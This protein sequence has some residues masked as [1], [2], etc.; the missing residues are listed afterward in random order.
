MSK[1]IE[2]GNEVFTYPELTHEQASVIQEAIG[3]LETRMVKGEELTQAQSAKHYCQLQLAG[4]QEEHFGC[5]FLDSKHRLIS[6]ERL[7]RGTLGSTH[8]Y[9]R[10]VLKRVVQTNAAAVIFT[11]NH[12]SGCP[13]PS[14]QDIR[15]T[16]QLIQLLS[17]I[18]VRVLDHIVVGTEGIESFAER[19]II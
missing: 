13:E 12:P 5:L 18:D 6:F 8:V 3:I 2:T 7:F 4:E 1:S 16:K 19:G 11:H 9:P 14:A 10:V 15:I 17:N